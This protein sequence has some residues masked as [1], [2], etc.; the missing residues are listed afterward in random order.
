MQIQYQVLL[1]TV[2]CFIGCRGCSL[3][4]WRLSRTTAT[5]YVFGMVADTNWWIENCSRSAWHHLQVTIRALQT[6]VVQRNRTWERKV[7]K[8]GW[9]FGMKS[10]QLLI[11][12]DRNYRSLLVFGMD[13]CWLVDHSNRDI[14]LKMKDEF[15][16][17]VLRKPIRLDILKWIECIFTFIHTWFVCRRQTVWR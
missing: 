17:Y 8:I 6:W 11:L 4:A 2:K 12:P 9:T 3:S 5:R 15:A 16:F 10:I 7:W 13:Q 14:C 1:F